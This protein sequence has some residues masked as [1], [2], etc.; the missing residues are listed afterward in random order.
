[1]MLD[2]KRRG[3]K[4]RVS[5][6]QFHPGHPQINLLDQQVASEGIGSRSNPNAGVQ[7][8]GPLFV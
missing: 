8:F 2:A 1:M 4:I 6:V 5:V 7:Y 3:L